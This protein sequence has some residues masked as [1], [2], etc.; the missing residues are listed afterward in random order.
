MRAPGSAC[1]RQSPTFCRQADGAGLL[2]HVWVVSTPA[3]NS[4]PAPHLPLQEGTALKR[5]L[6]HL[7]P[8]ADPASPA[9][10]AAPAFPAGLRQALLAALAAYPLPPAEQQ[11]G[12]AGED[13]KQ[14]L[15][16]KR[17]LLVSA[18][19]VIWA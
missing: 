19:Q 11:E 4:L 18:L 3:P 8:L 12:A 13:T 2:G 5:L 15:A 7:W 9:S 6:P 16:D 17:D 10:Q 14:H 1:W